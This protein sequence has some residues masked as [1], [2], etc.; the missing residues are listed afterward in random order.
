M[1]RFKF[2]KKYAMR[3][4][5]GA[6]NKNTLAYFTIID[7]ELGLEFRDVQLKTGKNGVF[8][9]SPFRSYEDKE[10]ETKYVNFWRASYD[11]ENNSYSEEGMAYTEAMAK[12]AHKLYLTMADGG[13]DDEDRPARRKDGKSGGKSS[14][15]QKSGRGKAPEVDEDEDEFLF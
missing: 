8:V 13:G 1:A 10:G 14:S 3:L 5:E 15:G 6:K 9:S 11:E 12:A 7:T 4:N 2:P